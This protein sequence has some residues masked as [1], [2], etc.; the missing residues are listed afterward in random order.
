MTNT[1]NETSAYS[2]VDDLFWLNDWDYTINVKLRIEERTKICIKIQ[3]LEVSCKSPDLG[4]MWFFLGW[5]REQVYKLKPK[6]VD[7]LEIP[8]Q[9]ALEQEI[10]W[11]QNLLVPEPR[12]PVS[13][14]RTGSVV[15]CKFWYRYHN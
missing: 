5:T 1:T 3:S 14:L 9:L 10:D 12:W 15:T 4:T 8:I 7:D 11:N 6:T 2:S 13:I